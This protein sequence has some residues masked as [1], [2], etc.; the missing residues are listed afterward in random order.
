MEAGYRSG[1]GTRTRPARVQRTGF[2]EG[3]RAPWPLAPQPQ[4]IPPADPRSFLTQLRRRTAAAAVVAFGAFFGLAAA[5]V[6]GVTAHGTTAGRQTVASPS[7]S[8][9]PTLAPGDFFGR[10]GGAISGKASGAGQAALPP[11]AQ[12]PLLVGGGAPMLSSGGS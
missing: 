9:A 5:N 1:M 6:V 10:P 8:A 3:H 7:A 11:V 4:A 2:V 12:P